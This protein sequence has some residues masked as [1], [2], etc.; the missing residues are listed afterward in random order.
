MRPNYDRA[1]D[2]SSGVRP[3][4]R[5][6]A[7]S[8]H[9]TRHHGF[10]AA[11][12]PVRQS[13]GEHCCQHR[14]REGP[15]HHTEPHAHSRRVCGP[16]EGD[17]GDRS[18]RLVPRCQLALLASI[19]RGDLKLGCSRGPC[20]PCWSFRPPRTLIQIKVVM[21]TRGKSSCASTKFHQLSAFD[22]RRGQSLVTCI[23]SGPVRSNGSESNHAAQRQGNPLP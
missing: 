15:R 5:L 17:P 21:G 3:A 23:G 4:N 22:P 14:H 20:Q 12:R 7:H 18:L 6:A 2:T 19:A 13:E 1:R 10:G 11:P 8:H 9:D 16:R